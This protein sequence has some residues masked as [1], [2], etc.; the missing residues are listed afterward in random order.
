[1]KCI[2]VSGQLEVLGRNS[3]VK[4]ML[5]K[6]EQETIK[7]AQPQK[8]DGLSKKGKKQWLHLTSRRP[9]TVRTEQE[10]PARPCA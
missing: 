2:Y 1:M 5:E 7:A 4:L 9:S 6:F 8:P 3:A 10:N